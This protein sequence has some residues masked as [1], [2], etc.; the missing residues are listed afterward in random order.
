MFAAEK[1]NN[2]QVRGFYNKKERKILNKKFKSHKKTTKNRFSVCISIRN[3]IDRQIN[4]KVI[5]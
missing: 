5:K 2:I 3:S 1:K 4:K